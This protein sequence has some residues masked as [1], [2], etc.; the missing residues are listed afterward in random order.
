MTAKG[1]IDKFIGNGVMAFR[2]APA[3]DPD[4]ALSACA[5][6]LALLRANDRRS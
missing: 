1:T 6:A 3:D 5:G 2:N 4:H